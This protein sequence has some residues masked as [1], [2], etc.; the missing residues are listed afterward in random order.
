MK[1]HQRGALTLWACAVVAAIVAAAALAAL[2]YMGSGRN[3]FAEGTAYLQHGA[4]G[5]AAE[6]AQAAA[7][8]LQGKDTATDATVRKC[9]V[10]G[11]VVYSNVECGKDNPTSRVVEWHDTRGFEAPKVNKAGQAAPA[12]STDDLRQKAVDRAV[13]Q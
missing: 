8:A 3:L 10:N 9:T 7:T 11:Q 13:D 1:R 5:R 4:A 6:R 2:F 12:G